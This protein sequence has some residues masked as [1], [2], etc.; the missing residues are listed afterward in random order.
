MGLFGKSASELFLNEPIEDM[1]FEQ[2]IKAIAYR[3]NQSKSQVEK[4]LTDIS[5]NEIKKDSEFN[6]GDIDEVKLFVGKTF[7]K[8]LRG[9]FD[10]EIEEEDK[11]EREEYLKEKGRMQARRDYGK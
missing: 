3:S 9:D 4:D 5:N 10:R 2:I 6:I 1:S 7:L 11:I 8:N